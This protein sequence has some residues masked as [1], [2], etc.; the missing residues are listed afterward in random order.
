MGGLFETDVYT[1]SELTSEIKRLLESSFA[2]VTVRGQINTLSRPRSGHVY[3]G[4][5][6]D[7]AQIRAVIW[8]AMAER[9][10]FDLTDGLEVDLQGKVT[11]YAPRGEY[12]LDVRKIEPVGVGTLELAFRQMYARLDQEGLFDPGR[13]RP[14]PRFPRRIVVVTSPTG[15]AVRD[16]LQ[17]VGRRWRGTEILIAPARVQGPGSAE[18]V[19]AAIAA[20]N[21]VAGADLIVV[22]RGGG[23]QED[24]WTFNEEA[25]ARAIANSRLPVISAIGHEIDITIADYVADVRAVTP[26]EAG[27]RCV[28]D[29]QEIQTR[30]E[31]LSRRLSNSLGDR[32]KRVRERLRNLSTRLA[33]GIR[34]VIRDARLRLDDLAARS[35][36]GVARCIDLRRNRLERIAASLE[37]L[38]PLGVLAR[39]YSLTAR[40]DGALVRATSDLAKGEVL[41]TRLHDGEIRSKIAEVRPLSAPAEPTRK[42]RSARKPRT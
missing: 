38:N 7:K 23:S 21:R 35:D 12:Q 42:P 37:A 19:V 8:R 24:L 41:I 11:L 39:G 18:E 9:I 20:A 34:D 28:P 17:V 14:L 30:L 6:D 26:S 16:F 15:A 25:V 4:L 5:K 32:L 29:M 27:E 36:R 33:R 31:L 2:D 13:K 22:T 1:V 3:F 40:E 10:R